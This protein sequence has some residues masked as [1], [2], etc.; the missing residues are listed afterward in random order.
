MSHA[1]EG[2]PFTSRA[3]TVAE[4]KAEIRKHRAGDLVKEFSVVGEWVN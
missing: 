2:C 3:A 1:R 4:M